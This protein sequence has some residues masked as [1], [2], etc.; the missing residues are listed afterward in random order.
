M[1]VW[2]TL[3]AP[4]DITCT[5]QGLGALGRAINCTVTEN[6]NGS[7]ELR[8]LFPADDAMAGQ[9][10]IGS[11]IKAKPSPY[12]D[13]QQF[14]VYRL[15]KGLTNTVEIYAAHISYDLAGAVVMPFT[16]Y[17]ALSAFNALRGAYPVP[18]FEF[19]VDGVDGGEV[20]VAV[21]R[22]V[23]S[24]IS[25]Q[26]GSIVDVCGGEL[27]YNN[28]QVILHQS[29]G[30][31]TGVRIRYGHNLTEL[32]EDISGE[33]MVGGLMPFWVSASDH[34]VVVGDVVTLAGAS[35]R[36][37]PVDVT[38]SIEGLDPGETPT[39]DQVTAAGQAALIGRTNAPTA[40]LT[41]NFVPLDTTLEYKGFAQLEACDIGDKITIEYAQLGIN[42]TAQI[43]ELEYDVLADRYKSVTVGQRSESLTSSLAKRLKESR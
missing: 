19:I 14:R 25:G 36:V 32:Q 21:P 2:P 13:G 23:K 28:R 35:D 27:E 31:E 39:K 18:D 22:T 40:Y 38:T 16:A 42:A 15:R 12:R 11:I 4:D 26:E 33:D 7:F 6:L 9:I 37:Q 29:R 3:H 1:R 34:S 30:R 43:T 41:V 20:T 5:T 24:V 17:G 10:G 8:M